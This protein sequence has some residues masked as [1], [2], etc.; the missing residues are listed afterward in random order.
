MA[1]SSQ[2]GGMSFWGG[3]KKVFGV[4]L[5]AEKVAVQIVSIAEPQL[6]PWLAKMDGWISRTQ[7]AILSV[8][9]TVTQAKAGGIK[10]ASVVADFENGLE[11]SQAA[12]AITGKTIQYDLALYKQVIADGVAFYNDAAAFKAGWKI[13]DLPKPPA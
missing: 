11:S 2:G 10:E 3:I 1:E 6:A 4:V 13:V 7:A 9:N 12:L 8:E 5:G